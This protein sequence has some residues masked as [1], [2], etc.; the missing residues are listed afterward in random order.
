[1]NKKPEQIIEHLI[2]YWQSG[3]Q[4]DLTKCLDG[5]SPKSISQ[6]KGRKTSD[7]QTAI[8]NALLRDIEYLESKLAKLENKK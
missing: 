6:Y 3:T 2:E 8:I 7:I 5:V 4:E 1:M